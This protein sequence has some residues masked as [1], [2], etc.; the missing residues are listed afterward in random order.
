MYNSYCLVFVRA[1]S[2][3]LQIVWDVIPGRKF[4]LSSQILGWGVTVVIFS[5]AMSLTGVSYRFGS[6]CHLNDTNS[7]A[8]C[9][10]YMVLF[11]GASSVLQFWR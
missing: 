1:L 5:I 6:S 4:F 2:M 11:A 8:S 7:L 3:H 10:I 9:W